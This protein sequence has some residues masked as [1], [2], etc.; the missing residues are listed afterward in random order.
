MKNK[1]LVLIVMLLLCLLAGAAAAECLDPVPEEVAF[2]IEWRYGTEIETE[3]FIRIDGVGEFDYGFALVRDEAMRR[4]VCFTRRN[5]VAGD[6]FFY[7]YSTAD[8][9]PQRDGHAHFI[10]HGEEHVRLV[11]WTHTRFCPDAQGFT[12]GIT[13]PETGEYD[14]CTVSYHYRDGAF[15]LEGYM[16]R[17]DDQ[18]AGYDEEGAL[19]YTELGKA[20]PHGKQWVSLIDDLRYIDFELLPKTLE[21]AQAQSDIPP[22]FP[23]YEHPSWDPLLSAEVIPFAGG[24]SYPVYV[25]PGEQYPRSGDGKAAVGTGGWI[26]V[27]GEHEGWLMIQYHIDGG[28]YRIGWIDAAAL[29]GRKVPEVRLYMDNILQEITETCILTDDPMGS[30]SEIAVLQ[31]ETEVV[32]LNRIGVEWEYVRVTIDGEVYYGFISSDCVTHG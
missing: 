18:A 15:R 12:V 19:Y 32:S 23:L 25:G 6:E 27:F 3:D 21:E 1:M 8:A 16:D 29:Q 4:L 2:T 28:R 22:G 20:I 5:D 26:Q 10:R 9:V 11:T 7:R 24:R 14:V 13:E 31:P 30:R 17:V